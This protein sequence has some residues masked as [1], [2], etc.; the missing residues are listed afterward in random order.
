M[1]AAYTLSWNLVF[2][3]NYII[4]MQAEKETM[5][6]LSGALPYK[7]KYSPTLIASTISLQSRDKIQSEQ[8]KSP[9][10][11]CHLSHVCLSKTLN[12]LGLEKLNRVIRK[13][14]PFR[15]GQHLFQEGDEFSSL[16]FIISG[17]VKSYSSTS[18]SNELGV[19]F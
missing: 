3:F 19:I 7:Q 8:L 14:S 12:T 18:N 16:Y 9:C 5:T 1:L 11:D 17:A 6:T 2:K 13:L 15:K 4:H 10:V